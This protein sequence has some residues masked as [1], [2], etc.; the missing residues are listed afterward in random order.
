MKRIIFPTDFSAL[1]LEARQAAVSLAREHQ[2]QL[3]I[4]HAF[5][6]PE[7]FA[8]AGTVYLDQQMQRLQDDVDHR[9]GEILGDICEMAPDLDVVKRSTVGFPADAICTIAKE[10]KD[11][12]IVMSTQGATGLKKLLLG[13]VTAR[14]IE[15]ASCPVLAIPQGTTNFQL[16]RIIYATNYQNEELEALRRVTELAALYHAEVIVLHVS[17]PGED[18]FYEVFTWYESLVREE[19][20]YP[21]MSFELLPPEPFQKALNN[22]IEHE[23]ADML[24]MS[25][26]QK[27]LLGRLFGSSETKEMSYHPQCP[28]LVFHS[29]NLQAPGMAIDQFKAQGF[30]V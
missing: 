20:E 7:V 19:L 13:S 28:L 4:V 18:Y 21:N 12:L 23:Q 27:G 24:A 1:S 17:E 29:E 2:A 16:K 26:R 15:A 11:S 9:L 25:K 5:A 6:P 30:T 3:V 10:E 14:V 22:F 8:E